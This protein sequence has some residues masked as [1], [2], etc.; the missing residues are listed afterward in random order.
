MPW[1]GTELRV[2][3]V[4]GRRLLSATQTVAGSPTDWISQP[5][6]S[7]DGVLHFVAE[8]DG[9][10][11]LHRL[12][13]GRVEAIAPLEAEYTYPDWLFGFSNY[14]FLADGLDHRDRPARRARPAPRRERE[15]RV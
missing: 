5:R 6:W 1:D 11:N 4:A 7:P 15:R 10:M 13:D 9:W 2:G 14:G 12:V 3:D 8:P